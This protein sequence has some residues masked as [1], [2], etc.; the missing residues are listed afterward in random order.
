[1]KPC[2]FA[3]IQEAQES[4]SSLFGGE[5]QLSLPG[6]E[7]Q[8]VR[9]RVIYI[10]RQPHVAR[11]I[12]DNPPTITSWVAERVQTILRAAG[13][14]GEEVFLCGNGYAEP[15]YDDPESGIIATGN[16]NDKDRYVNGKRRVVDNTPSRVG[17]LLQKLGVEIEW[18]DEWTTCDECGKLVRTTGNSYCWQK[19][20]VDFGCGDICDVCLLHDDLLLEE[21][22]QSI[23]GEHGK[24]CTLQSVDLEDAGYRLIEDGF[25]HGLHYG[26]DAS[27]EKIADILR[28]RGVDRFLFSLDSVG[29]FDANFSVW[30][31]ESQYKECLEE[32][33]QGGDTDGPSVAGACERALQ[34][35]SRKMAEL[36]DG[37]GVK[38]AKCNPDGTADVRLIDPQ[39]FVEKG[40]S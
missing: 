38:F 25:E 27:P 2:H 20:Y 4:L 39:T 9:S 22:L 30:V 11:K 36:P 37:P 15:E 23:E 10:D 14:F 1:M 17:D 35:A 16:W 6:I 32:A 7:V 8:A 31:H 3:S 13:D 24:C 29:Q 28:D 5:K 21:Y 26:Q 33:V 34:D 18:D 19:S 40:I 12:G